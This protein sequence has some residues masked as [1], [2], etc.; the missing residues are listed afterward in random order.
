MPFVTWADFF[1]V[2]F[3]AAKEKDNLLMKGDSILDFSQIIVYILESLTK[4]RDNHDDI[5]TPVN[6]IFSS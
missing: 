2:V 3:W 6:L 4:A 5:I 1:S